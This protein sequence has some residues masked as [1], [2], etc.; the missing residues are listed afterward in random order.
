MEW[1]KGWGAIALI[2]GALSLGTVSVDALPL[3][4]G[5]KDIG[6][7]VEAPAVEIAARRALPSGP[8]VG[9]PRIVPRRP[10]VRGPGLVRPPRFA[11]RSVIIGIGPGFYYDPYP[12][13]YEPYYFE[14][15]D[16]V[17]AIESCIR[18]FKSYDLRTRTY[19][20]Y[21]G[22]RHPCP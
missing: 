11:R 17:D 2:S 12:Y 18:R 3:T 10:I 21:D 19:L 4:A 9:A 13:Y 14:A 15:P 5:A 20:G 1:Q 8:R 6:W 16:D 22:L 7:G